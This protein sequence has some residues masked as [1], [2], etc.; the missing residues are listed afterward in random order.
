VPN[1][2]RLFI[3][4]A[5]QFARELE[6][7]LDLVPPQNRDWELAGFLYRDEKGENPLS[8][9]PSDYRVLGNWEVF[10]FEASDCCVLGVAKPDFKREAYSKL[11]AKVAFPPFVS[12][13][14]TIGKFNELSPGVIVCPHAIITT[15]IRI[16][17]G[18][19]VNIGTQIGHDSRIGAF[20]SLM[21]N[22]DIGGGCDIGES[23][24]IGTGSTII[25]GRRI[26]NGAQ[27]GAGSV[28]VTHVKENTRVFG[29]PASRY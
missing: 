2:K 25:P 3:I 11:A 15:N 14:C 9:V 27:I 7:W 29:N 16:G 10:P 12:P 21:P 6:S 24:F 8:Q 4:G 13:D 1:K 28:V 18:T 26:G 20:S 23:V 19:T 22:V 17:T 5:G